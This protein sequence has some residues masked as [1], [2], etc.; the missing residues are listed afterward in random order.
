VANSPFTQTTHV[1]GSKSKLIACQ[2]ASGVYQVLLKSVQWFC[3]RVWSKIALSHYWAIGLYNSL[4]SVQFVI[5][6]FPDGVYA[7]NDVSESIYFVEEF[8]DNREV[9]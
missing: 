7:R 8:V 6:D 5:R 9:S 2:V 1:A 4:I 3:R